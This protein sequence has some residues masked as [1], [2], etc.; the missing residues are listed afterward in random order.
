MLRV[1][2]RIGDIIVLRQLLRM[3]YGGMEGA[4]YQNKCDSIGEEECLSVI[5]GF[6]KACGFGS[7]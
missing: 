4:L 3:Q 5:H 2:M 7:G 6:D 1:C